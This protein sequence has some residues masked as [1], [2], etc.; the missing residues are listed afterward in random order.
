VYYRENGTGLDKLFIGESGLIPSGLGNNAQNCV[1]QK[2]MPNTVTTPTFE[3]E[4]ARWSLYPNPISSQSI[5][6]LSYTGK[7][8]PKEK[9]SYTIQDRMGRT[10]LKGEQIIKENQIRID[11]SNQVMSAGS[12]TLHIS[13]ANLL[14]KFIHFIK[15]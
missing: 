12:Y 3:I 9:V 2:S 6:T 14:P 8:S 4:E 11:L 13:G 1:A 15:Y 10:I 7:I 5:F